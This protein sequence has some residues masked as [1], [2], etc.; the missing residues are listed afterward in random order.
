M[1]NFFAAGTRKGNAL[2]LPATSKHD[3]LEV[4]RLL[5]KTPRRRGRAKGSATISGQKKK[6]ALLRTRPGGERHDSFVLPGFIDHGGKKG[7]AD[8]AASGP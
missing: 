8:T 7:V 3:R 4:L 1:K 2:A 6:K 5:Q